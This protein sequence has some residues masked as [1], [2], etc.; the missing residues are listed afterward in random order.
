MKPFFLLSS[1]FLLFACSDVETQTLVVFPIKH[2]IDSLKSFVTKKDTIQTINT[3]ALVKNNTIQKQPISK[4]KI[5]K[6][7]K[8]IVKNGL[9]SIYEVLSSKKQIFNINTKKS[10]FIEGKEGTV[11]FIPK[12]A[13]GEITNIQLQLKE[14]Y[15]KDSYLFNCLS[16]Q[17]TDNQVLTTAGM[18]KIEAFVDGKEVQLQNGKEI[19]IH[20]PK[21]NPEDK[22]YRLFNESLNS[23]SIVEWD[24]NIDGQKDFYYYELTHHF[25]HN[26]I[27]HRYRDIEMDYLTREEFN[28]LQN[29]MK[30]L[31]TNRYEFVIRFLRVKDSVLM[32]SK[33]GFENDLKSFQI[34]SKVINY[35]S[36]GF[37]K[38][39]INHP[40][41]ERFYPL[42]SNGGI[43]ESDEEY[44]R[45]FIH[46]F[47]EGNLDKATENELRYYVLRTNKLG[48][49]NCDKFAKTTKEKTDINIIS[50]STNED[51]MLYFKNFNGAI[52][53]KKY[54]KRSI[55]RNI[56]R[57]EEGV[58]I[59]IKYQDGK[60]F[61]GS[62]NIQANSNP[63]TDLK[64]RNVSLNKLSEQ[65][66]QLIN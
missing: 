42:F 46:K 8:F 52:R 39:Y 20:F 38:E 49:I 33:E 14:S 18:V 63:I 48:W 21:K 65:I 16:T 43:P 55:I 12:S 6:V 41:P 10:T 26:L 61:L 57:G 17:T 25:E 7:K 64:Y 1:I 31:S 53:A 60:V 27:S 66:N 23:D 28:Y 11:L 32:F 15:S 56:P 22:G 59:G 35:N 5:Q 29:K 45:K 24:E 2:P 4:L 3:L 58:L 44:Q 30:R 40:D 62:K 47:G 37:I 54:N 36:Q 50:K 9:D 34:I 19:T 51:F 13:F